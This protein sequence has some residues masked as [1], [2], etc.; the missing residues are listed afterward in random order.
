MHYTKNCIRHGYGREEVYRLV[1]RFNKSLG[2]VDK[3]PGKTQSRDSKN[4]YIEIESN[5]LFSLHQRKD[6]SNLHI[7]QIEPDLEGCLL[8]LANKHRI[9]ISSRYDIEANW[10]YLHK[11]DIDKNRDYQAF[12]TEVIRVSH[13]INIIK[14]WIK[15]YYS[16]N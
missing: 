9:D 11:I 4:N 14:T 16:N 1:N 10:D 8:I 12:V 2:V 6:N 5:G 3:D 7:I 15:K 13:E